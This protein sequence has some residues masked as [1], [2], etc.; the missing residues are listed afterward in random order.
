MGDTSSYHQQQQHQVEH[1]Q[2]QKNYIDAEAVSKLEDLVDVI[3]QKKKSSTRSDESL[4]RVTTSS[5]LVNLMTDREESIRGIVSTTLGSFNDESNA[6]HQAT[7]QTIKEA[8][9]QILEAINNVATCDHDSL[10]DVGN[11][12]QQQQ[13]KPYNKSRYDNSSCCNNNDNNT[14]PRT[15]NGGA[16]PIATSSATASLEE[17]DTIRDRLDHL[18]Q[19]ICGRESDF[20]KIHKERDRIQQELVRMVELM[21]KKDEE[22]G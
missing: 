14:Y 20:R 1:Q 8:T 10:M 6:D 11:T 7:R 16:T 22:L 9:S 18:Q 5:S 21:K 2:Q 15:R 4:H 17:V 19:T 13:Y 12:Q 3:L